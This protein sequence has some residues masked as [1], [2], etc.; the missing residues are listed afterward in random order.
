MQKRLS[1]CL[2]RLALGVVVVLQAVPLLA[3]GT[4]AAAPAKSAGTILQYDENGRVVGQVRREFGGVT[5]PAAEPPRIDLVSP[6]VRTSA[7]VPFF[8]PGEIL[9]VSAEA[10]FVGRARGLGFPVLQ[11]ARLAALGMTLYRLRTPAG[12][13]APDVL[14]TFRAA[15]PAVE[16]D[17]NAIVRPAAGAHGWDALAVVGWPAR[18]VSCGRGIA[19]GMIDTAVDEG[20][21]AFREG[22][23]VQRSFLPAERKPAAADH[24]TAIAALLI[25]NDASA[26]YQGLLPGTQLYAAS[27]FEESET[28]QTV[29]NVF[30]LIGAFDWMLESN[31]DVLNL[32]LETGEN[33]ILSAALDSALSSGVT[34]TA[35]AGNGGAT[36]LPAYPAAHPDVLA[37]T[38]IDPDLQAYRYAN[39]GDYIDFAAPGVSLWTAKP[40][41]GQFQSGTSFAVPFLTAAVAMQM[42]A[43]ADHDPSALRRSLSRTVRDLGAPGKD[44][45]YGW[46]LLSFG[47]DC[48]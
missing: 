4:S 13:S 9:A 26:G 1:R 17:V 27:I 24:G 29:G 20:H 33:R 10:D 5:V 12:A 28:G 41:G 38:A 6:P 48:G 36:A 42:A 45:V 14:A 43:G 31:V 46:G 3:L 35:A 22:Q 18:R 47:P 2:R 15:F 7:D 11:R 25:G 32:S 16:A 21:E 23:L 44:D 8:V 19:V 34:I 40:G 39:H 30:A 37:V